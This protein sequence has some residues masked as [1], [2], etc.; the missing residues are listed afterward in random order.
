MSDTPFRLRSLPG[1]VRLAIT[2]LLAVNLSGF[3]ASALHLRE[4]HGVRDEREGISYVDLESA[5]HGVDIRSPLVSALESGHP[6][7]LDEPGELAEADRSLLLEWL[8]SERI[9]DDYDNLD[10]GERAPA[11]I[12]ERSCTSCHASDSED[13]LAR[14][15]SLRYW[16]DVKR[17]AFSRQLDAVDENIL[18]ASTHTHA[19]SLA[20]TTLLLVLLM[21]CTGWSAAWRG[22]LSALA[23]VG[24]AT[25]LASWWL[26]RESAF[27]VYTVVAGGALYFG[28]IAL[29]SLMILVDLWRPRAAE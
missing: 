22:G 3:L 19:I 7:E 28:S 9:S 17:V 2:L 24:L 12:L 25:D 26:A 29:M 20:T 10:L 11:E 1:G 18:L 16:D 6:A 13:A 4:H 15:L 5:Y 23:G 14:E 21:A 27:F 8:A